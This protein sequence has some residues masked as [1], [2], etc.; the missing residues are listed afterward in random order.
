MMETDDQYHTIADGAG[1]IDRRTRGRLR[2][3]GD[4]AVAFLHAQVT[5]DVRALT[6]G[7]GVYAAY[8]TPQGRMTADLRIHHLGD[9]LIAGVAPGLAEALAKAF[10][11]RIFTENVRISDVSAKLA[12]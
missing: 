8:L 3:E 4:D 7:Q 10:E 11:Q 9:H 12:E 5:N 2:F 1:W 6:R